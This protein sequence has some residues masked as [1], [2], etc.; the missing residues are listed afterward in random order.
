MDRYNRLV[1]VRNSK[2]YVLN[3]R[4]FIEDNLLN[5]KVNEP[6]GWRKEIDLPKKIKFTGSW[7]MNSN[8]DLA[9]A[10]YERKDQSRGDVL[11][12][13]GN[14]LDVR[15]DAIL[16][17]VYSR[18]KSGKE[19]TRILKLGGRWQ[20][21]ENNRLR[22][23]VKKEE[24]EVDVLT[25]QGIWEVNRNHEIT[26][27]YE[28]MDLK[29]KERLERT[30]LFKGFWEISSSD[31]FVYILDLKENSYFSF[32]AQLETP[33]LI[34]KKGVIKYRVGIGVRGEG[35]A[36]VQIVSLFGT[37]KFGRKGGICFEID[38][39]EDKIKAVT[40]GANFYIT[41]RDNVCFE[42]KN[43]EGEDLGITVTFSRR[44]IRTQARGFLR[45]KKRE[46]ES[47]IEAGLKIPW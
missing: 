19:L 38:Y 36:S 12:L 4:F 30:I 47:R 29:T 15:S 24:R 9:L 41:T 43:K 2:S 16:F 20:A 46:R 18:T 45:L 1:M 10:L 11:S 40:F 32:K 23:L 34:G 25:L 44:F 37:W 28:K 17:E 3:G 22:F 35:P 33:N 14:I 26:Y 7:S 39:G 27:R 6:E 5:Y 13:K 31:R 42:L 21:D 8:H